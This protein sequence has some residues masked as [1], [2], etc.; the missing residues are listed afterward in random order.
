MNILNSYLVRATITVAI[1][2][3]FVG[4]TVY[5]SLE[6]PDREVRKGDLLFPPPLKVLAAAPQ[7][8][9]TYVVRS[10]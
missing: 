5:A 1:L 6:P 2:S 4:M 9:T 3:L 7:E 10:N 8:N